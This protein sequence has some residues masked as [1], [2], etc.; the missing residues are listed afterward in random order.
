M[1]FDDCPSG[2]FGMTTNQILMSVDW[3]CRVRFTAEP[4]TPVAEFSVSTPFP[5]RAGQ[6]I[7]FDGHASHVFDPVTGTRDPAD[8]NSFAW[9]FDA[10]GNFDAA[11]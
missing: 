8:I 2:A 10:D 9:D 11:G 5:R 1:W 3:L 4:R 6:V 7:T